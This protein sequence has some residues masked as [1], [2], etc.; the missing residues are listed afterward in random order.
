MVEILI[1][2]FLLTVLTVA[3][4]NS[5][6]IMT[7]TYRDIKAKKAI[8]TSANTLLN[9]FSYEVRRSSSVSGT[10]GTSSA[11]V[12]LVYGTTTTIISLES[13]TSRAIVTQNGVSDY[14]TSSD[15]TVN[16]LGLYKLQ[17]TGTMMQFSITNNN[18][19]PKQENFETSAVIRFNP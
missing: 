9:R 1:Y 11:N 6:V 7:K 14:L 12:S 19:T 3:L 13:S 8:I 17:A 15:V 18:G 4:T 10:F 16:S 5:L 2:I